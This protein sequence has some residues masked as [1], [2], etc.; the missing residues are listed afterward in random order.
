MEKHTT[1]TNVKKYSEVLYIIGQ[2]DVSYTNFSKAFGH[3]DLGIL[4]DK[5]TEYGFTNNEYNEISLNL[6]L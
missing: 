3:V 4:L 6:F 2:I 1:T 5:L